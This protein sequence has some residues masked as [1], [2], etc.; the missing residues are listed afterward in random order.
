ML[1]NWS[2]FLSYDPSVPSAIPSQYL[3]FNEHI[4]IGNNSVHFSYFLNH[5]INFIG[6]L[7]NINGTYKS[8]GAIKYE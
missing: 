1:Q 3:W 5:G 8:W 6:N 2:K 7:V 4:K